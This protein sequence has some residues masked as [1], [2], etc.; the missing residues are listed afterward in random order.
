MEYVNALFKGVARHSTEPFNF[1]CFT[2]LAEINTDE[3]MRGIELRPLPWGLRGWWNKLYLFKEGVLRDRVVFFDLDTVIMGNIDL[4]LQYRGKFAMVR[5]LMRAGKYQS[6]IMAW[7]AQFAYEIWEQYEAQDYP[8]TDEEGDQHFI[9]Q[10]IIGADLL[11]NFID[12]IYSYKVSCQNSIPTD[13]RIVCFHGLPRP[14]QVKETWLAR[15]WNGENPIKSC[16][17]EA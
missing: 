11:Q 17:A 1:V 2:D 13:A 9:Q 15:Y 4:L 7:D 14:H 6:C 5:D 8:Q 10:H 12:G 3:Y 16:K